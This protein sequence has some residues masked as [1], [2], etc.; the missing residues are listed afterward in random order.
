MRKYRVDEFLGDV[1]VVLSPEVAELVEEALS[2]MMEEYRERYDLYSDPEPGFFELVI[3][4]RTPGIYVV[5]VKHLI[6]RDC[7]GR[8]IADPT[9]SEEDE[10]EEDVPE[11][12]AE[13][14]RDLVTEIIAETLDQD[15]CSFTAMICMLLE[16]RCRFEGIPVEEIAAFVHKAVL[17]VNAE[18]GRL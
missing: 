14:I 3:A 10:E 9:F 7:F 16:L 5:S 6:T 1:N 4:N 18:R 13:S 12:D 11:E 15:L 17:D 8:G 2:E